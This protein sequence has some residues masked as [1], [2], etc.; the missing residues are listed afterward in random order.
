[1]TH[2][3]NDRDS[4]FEMATSRIR[5]G[6]GT[7]REVG[8]DFAD[9][10]VRRVL[11]VVDPAVSKLAPGD[12][13]RESLQAAGIEFEWFD[14]VR[15]EPSQ[16]SFQAAID[17]AQAGRFD[18]FVALGGGSTIDTAKVAN[19]FSTYPADFLTYVNAPLGQAKPIPGPLKPLIAIPTTAGTG[20]ETTGV[21]ICDLDGKHIKTG[22]AH[23]LLKPTLGVL[24]PDNTRTCPPQ[25]AASAGLDVLC[26]ALE[27]YTALPYDERP[28][29]DRPSL[30]PNY[31]GANPVSDVWVEKALRMVV[32]YL[33]RAYA[34]TSDDEARAN[35]LLAAAYAGIGFG[36][37]GVHL[38]H[39]LSYPIASQVRDYRAADYPDDHAMV[40][41]GISV[42]LTAP[43]VFAFTAPAC[44]ERHL[45]GAELLGAEITGAEPQ[46][47]GVI[48]GDRLTQLLV[49]FNIPNG[50]AAV[51][52]APV[53]VPD[54]A[55]GAIQQQRLTR[56]S[57][58][59]VELSDIESILRN[60]FQLW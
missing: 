56:L 48:L 21:A 44:P 29:P 12:V 53:D 23:R 9:W 60:S 58:R 26:H 19:L 20:S 35:M 37:A 27:S 10:G 14:Q 24:D 33:P 55:A 45:R 51:G 34:D 28:R 50:L 38:C 59:H 5:F 52:Y 3:R 13:L 46:D 22:I 2:P 18:G 16:S 43:A 6:P 4:G 40:P 57:P 7:T 41:H 32:E 31:Q 8:W 1:M 42:V 30:R 15:V 17:A 39:A 54:L 49:Q 36:N 25:V 47:A 11:A